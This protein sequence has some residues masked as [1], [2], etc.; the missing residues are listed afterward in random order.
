[1]RHDFDSWTFTALSNNLIGC[2][3]TRRSRAANQ[4]SP[5]IPARPPSGQRSGANAPTPQP[6]S[7]QSLAT[8][9]LTTRRC[10]KPELDDVAVG[11]A[12]LH[13]CGI[14]RS[15]VPRMP[16]H[17]VDPNKKRGPLVHGPTC[18]SA[19]SRPGQFVC[20]PYLPLASTRGCTARPAGAIRRSWARSPPPR[21]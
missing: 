7:G 4:P 21:S 3:G 17:Y 5:A 16:L 13:P 10:L 19:R 1:M 6:S 12:E 2:A 9:R 20:A 8:R 18:A 11:P 15:T 14:R